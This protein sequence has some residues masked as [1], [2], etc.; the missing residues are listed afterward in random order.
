MNSSE[1]S[2]PIRLL[3]LDGGGVHELSSLMILRDIMDKVN[4]GQPQGH[5]L[6]PC[7]VFDLI[8][9]TGTGGLVAL[10][11]GR[12]RMKLEDV[13]K[14]YIQL[15]KQVAANYTKVGFFKLNGVFDSGVL[16]HEIRRIIPA[17][18]VELGTP[19]KQEPLVET[20]GQHKP[21]KVF[22]FTQHQG[23]QAPA[24]LRTYITEDE[25][26]NKESKDAELWEAAFATYAVRPFFRPDGIVKIAG[27]PITDDSSRTP[28]PI[29][30]VYHEAHH[31][32]PHHVDF[33]LL[34]IGTG[35]G[36]QLRQM[37]SM[38]TLS[39]A[40]RSMAE[41]SEKATQEFVQ[42]HQQMLDN[43]RLFRFSVEKKL[44]VNES[45]VHHTLTSE[46]EAYLESFEIASEIESCVEELKREIQGMAPLNLIG[47][48]LLQPQNYA[49]IV[50]LVSSTMI[51]IVTVPIAAQ[52]SANVAK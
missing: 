47:R 24:I 14:E 4:E 46:V 3:S 7:D 36:P 42:R 28:N 22:V 49:V 11:L 50:I 40:L 33:F 2:G 6:E 43:H 27:Q 15:S 37:S 32:W 48:E 41:K 18:P 19:E 39:R 8:G 21:C 23:D 44:D 5:R 52:L 13:E 16:E 29:A 38:G 20:P 34:S 26:S 35:R 30:R 10:M 51:N 45:K 9:G 31:V 17:E 25:V 12:L 1:G